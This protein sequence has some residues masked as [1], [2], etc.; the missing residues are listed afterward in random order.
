MSAFV[1]LTVTAYRERMKTAKA[2]SE[3]RDK[4]E[5]AIGGHGTPYG[6][7]RGERDSV[8]VSAFESGV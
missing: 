7:I 4:R 1:P 8:V 2:P 6:P 5:E 3:T